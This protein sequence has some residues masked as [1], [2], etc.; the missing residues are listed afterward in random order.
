MKYNFCKSV[1]KPI[2]L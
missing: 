1:F 2:T